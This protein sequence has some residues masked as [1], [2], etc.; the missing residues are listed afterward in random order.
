M[1][2][3]VLKFLIVA[4]VLACGDDPVCVI[5]PCPQPVAIQITVRASAAETGV[6]GTFVRVSG[7]GD[8]ACG[9]SAGSCVVFG[10][11]GTY[12]LEIGAPGFQTVH[13]TVEVT[14]KSALGCGTCPSVNTQA[15]DIVLVP[16]A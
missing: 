12:Q 13:R 4:S 1:R 8:G 16:A 7:A 2:K 9:G 3:S 6:A 14:G 5:G 11:A 10:Y 15:L